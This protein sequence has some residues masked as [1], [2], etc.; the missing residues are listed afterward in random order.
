MRLLVFALTAALA[1]C[2]NGNFTPTPE[3]VAAE[4]ATAAARGAARLALFKECMELAA[5]LPR[6]A[7]DDVADVVQQCSTQ[8]YYMTNYIK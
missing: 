8:A 5:K 4:E 7:D 1:A 3:S 6:Q 2:T